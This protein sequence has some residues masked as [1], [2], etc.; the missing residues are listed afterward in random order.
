MRVTLRQGFQGAVR[1]IS[2]G[3][4]DLRSHARYRLKAPVLFSWEDADG[5]LMRGGGFTRD[6]SATGAFIFSPG[7]PPQGMTV[8]LEIL[9][10]PLKGKEHLTMVCEARV[11]RLENPAPGEKRDGF[12]VESDGFAMLG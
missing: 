6:L 12:A 3:Q 10:P 11:I 4:V 8:R 5:T 9:L 2:D 7:C 1:S